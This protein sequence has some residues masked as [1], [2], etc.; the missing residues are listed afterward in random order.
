VTHE[1]A[2]DEARRQLARGAL[3]VHRIDEHG[4]EGLVRGD[5][6]AVYRVAYEHGVW[7]CSCAQLGFCPHT[8]CLALTAKPKTAR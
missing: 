1:S 7:T 2:F 8:F 4:I 5:D 6:E 3:V